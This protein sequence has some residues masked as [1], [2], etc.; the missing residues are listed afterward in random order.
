MRNGVC[1]SAEGKKCMPRGTGKI[2]KNM[3]EI[4]C[5]TGCNDV[6]VK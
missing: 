6:V 1:M 3:V 4:L 5:D 2:G